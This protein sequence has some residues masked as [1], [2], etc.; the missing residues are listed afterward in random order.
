MILT[1]EEE[2]KGD[3][4]AGEGW[5]VVSQEAYQEQQ[6]NKENPAFAKLKDLFKD[7]KNK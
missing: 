5:K 1:P 7:E 3:F 6:S 2:A 4:P